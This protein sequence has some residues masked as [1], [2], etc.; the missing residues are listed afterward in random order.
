MSSRRWWIWWLFVIKSILIYFWVSLSPS[1]SKLGNSA[2]KKI[3][4]LILSCSVSLSWHRPLIS[5]K[6]VKWS[7]YKIKHQQMDIDEG[8]SFLEPEK[9]EKK[10]RNKTTET[11][12]LV[13]EYWTCCCFE[14]RDLLAASSVPWISEQTKSLYMWP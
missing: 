12:F 1:L 14:L 13:L 5:R 8:S 4:V 10:S 2:K 9:R 3:E 11:Y 7:L 6:K